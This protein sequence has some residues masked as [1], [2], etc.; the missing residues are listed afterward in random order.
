MGKEKNHRRENVISPV[1]NK[2][3]VLYTREK[4]Q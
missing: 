4:K 1:I 2:I 3:L